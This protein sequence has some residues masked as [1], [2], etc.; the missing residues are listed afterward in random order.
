[1]TGFPTWDGLGINPALLPN[2]GYNEPVTYGGYVLPRF[3]AYMLAGINQA[4]LSITA[5]GTGFV[6][7]SSTSTTIGTG[8]KSLTIQAGKGFVAGMVVVA[9]DAA[10]ATRFI[11]GEVT[12]YNTGT[13]ALVISVLAGDT[14]G[15][16]TVTSWKVSIAGRRGVAGT[17]WLTGTSAP[18]DAAGRDGDF[19]FRSTTGEVYYKVGGTWGSAIADLTGPGWL[20]GSG[21]PSDASG[22][23]GDYFFRTDTGDVYQ[24]VAGTWGSPVSNLVGSAW[25]TGSG[26]PS[27]GS[28]D[29]GDFYFRTSNGAVYQK[30]AG[31]WGSPIAN[32]TGP[33]GA[34]GSGSNIHVADDGTQVTGAP[35]PLINFIGDSVTAVDNPDQ[36]RVDVT[37]S[38]TV[39]NF[40]LMAQ[41][42]N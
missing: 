26:V 30:A 24:K 14:G 42:I 8:S 41:G 2:Y 39:P 23:D 29:N 21:A 5:A 38:A 13:G 27:D 36:N 22:R 6:G 4:G 31:T 16:G 18:S 37:V 17:L 20:S 7:T 33:Q 3:V 25:L 32:L 15:T 19:Y 40:L 9:W 10:D 34:T 11:A 35:R 12:S 28:G 1:M